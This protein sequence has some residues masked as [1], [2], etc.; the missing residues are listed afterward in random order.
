MGEVIG[1]EEV[2]VMLI[3]LLGFE[4]FLKVTIMPKTV[5]M[6]VDN[7]SATDIAETQTTVSSRDHEEQERLEQEVVTEPEELAQYKWRE[8]MFLVCNHG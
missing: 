7:L 1:E 6:E 3:V 2:H 8:G 5:T 4:G